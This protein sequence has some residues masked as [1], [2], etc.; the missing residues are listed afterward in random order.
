M[1][2]APLLALIFGFMCLGPSEAVGD[3]PMD[4]K[5]IQLMKPVQ[6]QIEQAFGPEY[7]PLLKRKQMNT[8]VSFSVATREPVLA[9]ADGTVYYRRTGRDK[10]HIVIRHVEGFE[11]HYGNISEAAYESESNVKKGDIIG[12][13]DR[14]DGNSLLYYEFHYRGNAIDPLP[15]FE[16]SGDIS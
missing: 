5:G 1:R 7:N 15:F 12:F 2:C 4:G 14:R 16:Q 8:G 9:T 13:F 11:S 6:G 3:G 10:I